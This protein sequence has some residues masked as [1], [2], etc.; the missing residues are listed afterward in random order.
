MD[1]RMSES[2][3]SKAIEHLS[4][5]DPK[6]RAII[7]TTS[8]IKIHRRD[9]SFQ[10]L[11]KI[12]VNQQLSDKAANT[13][14]LRIQNLF[15]SDEN[16]EAEPFYNMNVTKLRDCGLSNAKVGYAKGGRS[17]WWRRLSWDF[18][19]PT[20]ITMPNHASTSLCHPSEVRVLSVK[21]YAKIQEFPNGWIFCGTTQQKYT[22]IGNAVPVKLGKVTA[23]IV[24]K[25][26]KSVDLNIYLEE[27]KP[28]DR[29]FRIV[30]LQSHVR[31]R[32]WFKNGQIFSSAD[33]E[34]LD[35]GVAKTF[36]KI[37]KVGT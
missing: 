22:Q 14:F 29:G 28:A 11:L 2:E 21:E 37:K 16:I 35:Y 15:T 20:L 30:Y 17:G 36:R 31:T 34:N 1:F 13:I 10:S 3:L 7:K 32:K 26:L 12:I 19:C 9:M 18:P 24:S 23:S 8:D 27:Y 4:R 25:F 5:V 33:K 6:I